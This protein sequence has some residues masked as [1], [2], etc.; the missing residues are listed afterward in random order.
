MG[1][2]HALSLGF[3]A[4][5]F[6][7]AVALTASPARAD[8]LAPTLLTYDAPEECPG[9]AEFQRSVQRRSTRIQFV[10]EGSHDRELSVS[11]KKS[12]EWVVGEL[13]LLDRDGRL[14]QRSVRFTSCAEAVEGLALIATVSLDP[15]AL[16]APA[17]EPAEKPTPAP[18]ETTPPPAP[19]RVPAFKQVVPATPGSGVAL[20][21]EANAFFGALPETS[22]GG[23]AL[24]DVGFRA[25]R[26]FSPMIRAAV[27]HAER[28]GLTRGAGDANFALTLV[29]LTG[30]PW[31]LGGRV[32][33]VLPCAWL[34]GGALRSWGTR[35]PDPQM[36]TRQYWAGGGSLLIVLHTGEVVEIVAD[37]GVGAPFIRDRF[38]FQDAEFW[39]T[40]SLYLSTGLGIRITLE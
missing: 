28:R 23:S 24:V 2:W 7:C 4:P 6:S 27:S 31:R 14:R 25:S 16:L 32:L 3:I 11:L 20:G 13:R 40:P 18:P 9:T 39:R 26:L 21:I 22:F 5:A 19:P 17:P 35:T 12:G 1:Y 30:C 15:E 34:G 10:D 33:E 38:A 36:R 37:A 8:A 29:T